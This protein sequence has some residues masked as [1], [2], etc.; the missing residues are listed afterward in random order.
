MDKPVTRYYEFGSFRLDPVKRLLLRERE[1][2]TLTAKAFEL[3]LVLVENRGQVM[4][5]ETLLRR[6]WPDTIVEEANLSVHISALRKA[7]GENLKEHHF[8]VTLAG[9]GYQFVA[10]VN[11]LPEDATELIVAKHTRTHL[12]IEKEEETEKGREKERK[13]DTHFTGSALRWLAVG[14]VFVLLGSAVWWWRAERF[15][16][17]RN[18]HSIAVLPL[19]S[20][21]VAAGDEYLGL[22]LADALITRLSQLRQIVVRPTSAVRRY[23]Q[24]PPD[25]QAAGQTLNVDAVLEGSLRRVGDRVRVTLRLIRTSDGQ[26]LWADQF[27][28]K[29]TDLLAV[30]DALAERVAEAM[31]LQLS[32]D[33]R[34]LFARHYTENAAAYQAYLKGRYHWDKRNPEGYR[35]GLEFFQQ[36]IDL[37]P[38]YAL[39]YAGLADCYVFGGGFTLQPEETMRRAEAAAQKAL[40]MDEQLAEA[41]TSLA[42]VKE[43]FHF[44]R[45]GAAQAYQRAL[46][47][48]RNYATAHDWYGLFLAQEGRFAEA[49]AELKLAQQ[50]EPLSLVLTTDLA[51]V[52]ILARQYDQGIAECRKALEMEPD[53]AVGWAMLAGA[54]GYQGKHAEALPAIQKAVALSNQWPTLVAQEGVGH[55]LSGQPEAARKR[56]AQLEPQSE[57][58]ATLNYFI[59]AIY[60][61]LGEKERAFIWLERAYAKRV[62]WL[63][64]LKVDPR[65]ERLR[66]DPRLADLLRRVGLRP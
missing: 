47:L 61:H 26:S 30:E 37:D 11:E 45:A 49:I 46:E 50:L 34:R 32:G 10:E 33:E 8:I 18:V 15:R 44:D 40:A 36:A 27:D 43:R 51:W 39:A 4:E 9:R 17:A 21:D 3:L 42:F 56:L 28:E 19:Q 57:Q 12:V 52:Y 48:N 62:G 53:F 25:L 64:W 35:K 23:A 38:A 2:V 16:P 66:D 65:F 31:R 14:L 41:H 20:L 29:F 22:G 5:K 1:P 63:V 24:Q 7:L 13:R 59:A 60:L 6:L 58:T 55:A 54:Y